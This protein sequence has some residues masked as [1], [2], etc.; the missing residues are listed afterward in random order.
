LTFL[1]ISPWSFKFILLGV[2]LAASQRKLKGEQFLK[3]IYIY[4]FLLGPKSLNPTISKQILISLSWFGG[5]LSCQLLAPHWLKYWKKGHYPMTHWKSVTWRLLC[6]VLIPF[7]FLSLFLRKW[8]RP[9]LMPSIADCFSLALSDAC[10]W[11]LKWERE[12]QS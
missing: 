4:I 7:I 8:V 6:Y 9:Q 11:F 5:P 3:Y 12:K 2:E 1:Q 10:V